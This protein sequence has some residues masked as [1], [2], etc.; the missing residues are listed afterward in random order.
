MTDAPGPV[1][2]S[3]QA[4]PAQP[5]TDSTPLEPNRA[6]QIRADYELL[7][8]EVRKLEPFVLPRDR[9]NMPST[10]SEILAKALAVLTTAGPHR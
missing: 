9:Y 3:P 7:A 1:L 6:D 8:A 4:L 10:L 5:M 2:G